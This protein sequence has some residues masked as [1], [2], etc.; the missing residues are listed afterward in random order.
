MNKMIILVIIIFLGGYGYAQDKYP[1]SVDF[2]KN[3]FNRKDLPEVF[4]L[5]KFDRLGTI[6]TQ[7]A[8][9]CWASSAMGSVES[10]RKSTGLE[11]KVFSDIHL[12]LFHGFDSLR[13]TSG[14]HYMAT[15]YFSRGNG[16][17]IKNPVT[18]SI[19]NPQ[20]EIYTYITDARYLPNDPNIVKQIIMDYGAVYSMMYF[21]PQYTDSTTHVFYTPSEKINHAIMLI[22]WN[23]TLK[24]NV[25]AGVW[26]A[27]NSLGPNFGEDGFF[28][29]PY[30]DPNIL[31]YNAVWPEWMNYHK[32]V[33]LY[34]Y[35]T[36]GSYN[37]YGFRDTICYGLVKY[38]SEEDIQ[39][40]K[41]GT[42]VNFGSS[43]IY[44]EVFQN[45][46]TVSKKLSGY[47]GNVDITLCRF[48]GYYT[49][50]L[51]QEIHIQKGE[52]FYIMMQYTTP[53][54]TLPLPVETFIENYSDPHIVEGKCWIN[55]NYEKWPTT[56]YECGTGSKYS[57]LNFDL[58]IKAY[59]IQ[60][61]Q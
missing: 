24:T 20:P 26:I 55:P 40:K 28:Y 41:I 53:Y 19:F 42:C 52:D 25:G 5:R 16:P 47:L 58:C 15:A 12:K 61:S 7:P 45:F 33:K 50:E 23:D 36:L 35:D 32:N 4:D 2:D 11:D 44:G 31:K 57:T 9:G 51:N 34:Y 43:K 46:D 49:L 1:S 38:V 29:I 37:S 30:Q 27:Q 13:S 3:L 14:N 59:C 18:D 8:G 21:R 6:K 39:L 60:K 56:W 54:D 22:G 17:L 48:A 10:F